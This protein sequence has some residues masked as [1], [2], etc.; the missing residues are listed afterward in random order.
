MYW[1][2]QIEEWLLHNHSFQNITTFSTSVFRILLVQWDLGIYL[3]AF[4]YLV[5]S[6]VTR[7]QFLK[8]YSFLII[9]MNVISLTPTHSV[10]WMG[11]GNGKF[12]Y[13][14]ALLIQIG[15]QIKTN[16]TRYRY[17]FI[18]DALIHRC[19]SRDEFFWS[20][21]FSWKEKK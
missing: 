9:R 5:L 16:T 7:L 12:H 19:P 8:Y 6:S 17:L 20:Y 11:M 2:H 1:K 3:Y 13:I 15:K 18:G 10:W 14:A 21:L 4:L